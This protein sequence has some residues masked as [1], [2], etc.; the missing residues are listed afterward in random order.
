[1]DKHTTVL[2]DQP[3]RGGPRSSY[4]AAILLAALLAL[5]LLPGVRPAQ[6]SAAAS[7]SAYF[8]F[9]T[10]P[11]PETFIFQLADSA[12]I[13][14]AR[15]ILSGQRPSRHIAGTIVK[16]PAAYNPPWNFHL[17][18]PS[19]TFFDSAIEVC[20]ASIQYVE[21]HLDEACG[22]F[23][24]GC[25]WCPWRSRLLAE[26]EP[27]TTPLPTP[28]STP[29]PLPTPTSTPTPTPTTTPT[30]TPAPTPALN[31]YLPVVLCSKTVP[32]RR[33]GPGRAR[34]DTTT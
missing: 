18:P 21:A 12:T 4:G 2:R 17:A 29:T 13:Q 10:P 33:G 24:P 1:M 6:P 15:A 19:I 7:E 31:L 3:A 28:T 32:S 9:D 11:Y 22:A 14:E 26:I 20:D 25:T 34:V 23:L 30:Q 27:D 16:K 5:A 8:V